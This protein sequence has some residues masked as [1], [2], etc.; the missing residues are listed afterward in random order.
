MSTPV[1]VAVTPD[2]PADRAGVVSGDL[3]LSINGA[4]PRD[5]IE[6]QLLVDEPSVCLD[7]ESGGLSRELSVEKAA[8]EPLGIEVDSALFDRVRTCDNHCEFCFVYQLPKGLRPSLYVKDDDYRLS[9]LYGNFTT[10][11]RFTEIDLERVV[12]ERLSPLYV[13]IHATDPGKRAEMLR[14]RRGATSLRWLQVLLAEGIEVHGQ[15]VVCPGL[16]DGLWLEDTLAGVADCYSEL[17]S[18]AVV[19]LGV[20]DH[21][22]EARMRAHTIEE[23]AAVVDTVAAW[24]EY[25]L[26]LLGRRLVFAA[27]EYFLLADRPFPPADTYGE[28]DMYEDGIGMARA[29]EMEFAGEGAEREAP[30]GFFASVDGAPA[31]GYRA[32]RT[33]EGATPVRLGPRPDAPV[34]VLTGELGAKVIAPIIETFWHDDVEVLA[35]ENRFFGGNVGVTGLL[36]GGDLARVLADVPEGRRYLLPDVCLSGGRFLDGMVPADLPRPVEVVATDGAALRSALAGVAPM[37][38]VL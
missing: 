2:S 7:V 23:A 38:V 1:V 21:T 34:T 25:F 4:V 28:F 12:T 17:A 26:A 19:P 35:V 24:Q 29:F 11:T 9:F 22:T 10:L 6:Y 27:D 15:V 36:V 16:N 31:G 3:I 13:S 33:A 8:G 37:E 32:P 18:L 5:V 14:N 20:S 30:S